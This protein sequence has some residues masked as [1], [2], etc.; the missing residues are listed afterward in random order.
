MVCGGGQPGRRTAP[1]PAPRPSPTCRSPRAMPGASGRL[2][3]RSLGGDRALHVGMDL[4]DEGVCAG[5]EGG[6]LVGHLLV[7]DDV[8]GEDLVAR[9]VGDPDVVRGTVLV[10][11]GN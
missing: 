5:S 11:E 10:V 3:E 4:A 6:D 1:A 7:R 9:G 2:A 8:S